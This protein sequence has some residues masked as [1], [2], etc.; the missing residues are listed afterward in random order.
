MAI[1]P[2]EG[3]NCAQS[4][5]QSGVTLALPTSPRLWL[6]AAAE[7]ALVIGA[8][9]WVTAHR[10][11]RGHVQHLTHPRTTAGNMSPAVPLATVVII[12]RYADQGTNLLAR[13]RSE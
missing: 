12:G 11:E 7:Q 10:T 2:E 8:Q 9:L 3:R 13:E 5:P 1:A 4:C 6:D